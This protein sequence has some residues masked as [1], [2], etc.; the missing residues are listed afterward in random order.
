MAHTYA[1]ASYSGAEL[2]VAANALATAI[3]EHLTID[4]QNVIGNLLTLVGTS[5]LSIAA[6]NQSMQKGGTKETDKNAAAAL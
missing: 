6:I 1:G 4:E 5:L 2:T 3:S